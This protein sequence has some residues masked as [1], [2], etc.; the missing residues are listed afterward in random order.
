MRNQSNSHDIWAIISVEKTGHLIR[1]IRLSQK[2]WFD[3]DYS[4]LSS[5]SM[6]CSSFSK[7]FGSMRPFYLQNKCP[8]DLFK[9]GLKGVQ[10]CALFAY[11]HRGL[12]TFMVQKY[13]N[14]VIFPTFEP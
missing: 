7:V 5:G 6:A 2:Y 10:K 1:Y 3:I 8:Q 14:F 13:Q 11:F 12:T 9:L 4:I